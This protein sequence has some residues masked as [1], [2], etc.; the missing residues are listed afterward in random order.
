[1]GQSEPRA[2]YK[3][4]L[5]KTS[6]P[7]GVRITLTPITPTWASFWGCLASWLNLGARFN[8]QGFGGISFCP[9]ILGTCPDDIYRVPE[10]KMDKMYLIHLL[11]CNKSGQTSWLN[12][13]TVTSH[14]SAGQLDSSSAGFVWVHWKISYIESPRWPHHGSADGPGCCWAPQSFSMWPLIFQ[15]WMEL[16]AAIC[17]V[18]GEHPKGQR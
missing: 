1:M 16:L 7:P 4:R 17:G 14:S 13:M 8:P 11:L 9:L 15:R 2:T 18:S 10:L 12:F 3:R 6:R 5:P